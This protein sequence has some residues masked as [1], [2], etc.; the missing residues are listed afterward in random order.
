M[1]PADRVLQFGQLMALAHDA[2]DGDAEWSEFV[3][4]TQSFL[5]AAYVGV[6]LRPRLSRAKSL[7]YSE[8][9]AYPSD[10]VDSEAL[11]E[12]ACR[13]ALERSPLSEDGELRIIGRGGADGPAE[14]RFLAGRFSMFVYALFT[15]RPGLRTFFCVA[16]ASDAAEFSDNQLAAIAT[17]A[18]QLNRALRGPKTF[19]KL[20]SLFARSNY[21]LLLVDSRGRIVEANTKAREVLGNARSGGD[22]I[23]PVESGGVQVDIAT[24]MRSHVSRNGDVVQTVFTIDC[25][26]GDRP[27]NGVL[28]SVPSEWKL[29]GPEPAAALLVID[30]PAAGET[31]PD[32]VL[33]SQYR[34]TPRE[35]QFARVLVR[36]QA[37][38][39]CAAELEIS[40]E[41]A[42]RHVKSV[43]EK[44]RTHSQTQLIH[45][46][47]RHPATALMR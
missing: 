41:T 43:F 22:L 2:A 38:K 35:A 6:V 24:L 20:G 37:L 9:C 36:T 33:V 26:D 10:D 32:E 17:I 30:D 14:G 40:Q 15:S 31:L 21:G 45:L 12:H 18:A 13:M 27:I 3:N 8:L 7:R 39:Q 47:S 34:L 42:R 29:L 46:L 4:A 28:T 11:V 44:T 25:A 1:A 23:G 19:Q 5:D 16:R